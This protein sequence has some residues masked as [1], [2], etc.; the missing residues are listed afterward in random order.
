M[1]PYCLSSIPG[2]Y[3]FIELYS[4]KN[5]ISCLWWHNRI[6][7]II[8]IMII[9]IGRRRRTTTTTTTKRNCHLVDFAV[10]TDHRV[11]INESE[12]IHNW[13]DLARE[14]KKV[15]K[16]EVDGDTNRIW[17]T[18]NGLQGIEKETTV[19]GEWKNCGR[20]VKKRSWDQR[21]FWEES[22]TK[23]TCCHSGFSVVIY[24]TFV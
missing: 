13:P 23:K 10:P 21:E 5:S 15:E 20:L 11:R 8:I 4:L 12:K 16:H 18:L 14:L 19:T 1:S 17:S 9:I 7:M 3:L 22:K 6:I 24:F 2:I